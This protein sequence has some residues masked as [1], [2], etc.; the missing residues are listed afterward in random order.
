MESTEGKPKVERL[1]MSAIDEDTNRWM[2]SP[3]L[4]LTCEILIYDQWQPY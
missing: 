2:E 3:L 4:Y 1:H